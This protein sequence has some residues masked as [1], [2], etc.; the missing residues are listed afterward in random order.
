MRY[1]M[2][3]ADLL[4]ALN[5][6]DLPTESIISDYSGRAMYGSTCLGII[7]TGPADIMRFT[8]GLESVLSD[9]DILHILEDV[10][11]DNLGL[12]TVLYMPRVTVGDPY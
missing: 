2:P 8:L 6:V 7:V 4:A 11:T 12:D 5:E 9:D 3:M 1:H 10:R